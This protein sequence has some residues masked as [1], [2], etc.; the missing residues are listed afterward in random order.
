MVALLMLMGGALRRHGVWARMLDVLR[1]FFW[2]LWADTACPWTIWLYALNVLAC[3]A[4]AKA[5][6]SI[7]CVLV[8]AVYAWAFC[9]GV[10]SELRRRRSIVRA[11]IG[12]P[13]GWAF[14]FVVIAAVGFGAALVAA[15]LTWWA[16]PLALACAALSC[17][18]FCWAIDRHVAEAGKITAFIKTAADIP[19]SHGVRWLRVYEDGIEFDRALPDSVV[20]LRNG[21]G[22]V[23]ARVGYERL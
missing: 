19:R 10:A 9:V 12:G 3:V 16:W 14:L 20:E 21:R 4:S 6:G 11:L 2:E 8:G 1:F 7:V 18:G 17:W 15:A 23:L 22:R 13:R 5:R